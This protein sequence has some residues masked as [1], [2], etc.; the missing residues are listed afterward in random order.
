MLNIE[1]G[2]V[3]AFCPQVRLGCWK[4]WQG[5]RL[6]ARWRWTDTWQTVPQYQ[7]AMELQATRDLGI[8]PSEVPFRRQGVPWNAPGAP[9][10]L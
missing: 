2:K 6:P 3:Q 9:E 8:Q 5:K 7:S 4:L 1:D 10:R